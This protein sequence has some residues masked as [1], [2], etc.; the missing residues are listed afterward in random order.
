MTPWYMYDKQSMLKIQYRNSVHAKWASSFTVR[1]QFRN[2][3]GFFQHFFFFFRERQKI[4]KYSWHQRGPKN[5]PSQGLSSV[6]QFLWN[7]SLGKSAFICVVIHS[8]FWNKVEELQFQRKSAESSWKLVFSFSI[9]FTWLWPST[10]KAHIVL[11]VLKDLRSF[12]K[13]KTEETEV[14][15]RYNKNAVV[16]K[17]SKF[18]LCKMKNAWHLD[19]PLVSKTPV[20][21][22]SQHC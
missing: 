10:M 11:G 21:S 19:L 6:C 22:L 9:G 7:Q 2:L 14:I 15:P 8:W 12:C 5:I 20:M 4:N 18:V 16:S 3:R 13:K 1:M 17:T